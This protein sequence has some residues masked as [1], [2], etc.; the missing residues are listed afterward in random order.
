MGEIHGTRVRALGAIFILLILIFAAGCASMDSAIDAMEEIA[1]D[2]ADKAY[3]KG[4]LY[5][6]RTLAV[7]YF[8]ENGE[9]SD[10]SDYLIDTLTSQFAYVVSEES[11]DISI[12]SRQTLDRIIKETQ[13][14]LSA[15]ADEETQVALGK[16]LGADMILTGTLTTLS[17]ED[18][19]YRINAQLLDVES[20]TVLDAFI[21]EFYME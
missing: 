8:T 16:Q 20:G 19:D 11:L 6:G 2:F 7:Y 3:E 18:G 13:F 4:D 15:M 12:V 10:I 1:W 5:L 21:Y 17:A 9:V 14:Q